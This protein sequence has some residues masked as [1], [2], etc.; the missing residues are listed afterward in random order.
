MAHFVNSTEA[1]DYQDEYCYRCQNWRDLK[2]GRDYGC[3]IM[4]AH[5]MAANS[6]SDHRSVLDV[7]I[8]SKPDGNAGQCSMFL[9]RVTP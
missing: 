7:L 3:P 4:D 8:P 9:E 2:D 1:A 5:F 6:K